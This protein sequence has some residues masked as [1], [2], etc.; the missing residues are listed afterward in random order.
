MLDFST[1]FRYATGHDP[2]PYQL[3]L[4]EATESSILLSV[5]TGLGKTDAVVMAWLYRRRYAEHNVQAATPRRLVYCLPMRS[6]VEQTHDKVQ[7]LLHNLSIHDERVKKSPVE[8]TVLM[9]G[10]IDNAWDERPENDNIII[11]TQ[12]QLLSRALNRGYAM[13]RYRWPI[14]FGLLNNDVMWVFD[15]LQLLGSAVPTSAQLTGFR[16]ELGHYGPVQS[17]WMSATMNPS[18]LQTP[19]F[20]PKTSVQI[21]L[22]NNDHAFP[23]VKQRLTAS[24]PLN[25]S[26]VPLSKDMTKYAKHLAKEVMDK[27]HPAT[28]SLVVLNRVDRVQAVAETLNSLSSTEI[29]VVHS[30]FR[31]QDRQRILRQIF[32][33][34]PPE[35]RII[36]ATQAVEAGIDISARLLISELAPWASMVQRFGRLNRYGQE[37]G[38]QGLWVDMDLDAISA[39]D[40]SSPYDIGDLRNS[41]EILGTLRDVGPASLPQKDFPLGILPVIRRKDIVELFDTSADLSGADIDIA[42]FVRNVRDTDVSV[43]WRAIDPHEKLPDEIPFPKSDEICPVSIGQIRRYLETKLKFNDTSR[44]EIRHA[45]IWNPLKSQWDPLQVQSIR[46]GLVVMLSSLEGG[47]LP[48]MGFSAA[49]TDLVEEIPH[50]SGHTDSMSGDHSS[51]AV[52]TIVELERH[53]LDTAAEVEELSNRLP[54]GWPVDDVITAGRLHDVG[55]AHEVFQKWLKDGQTSNVASDKLWAKSPGTPLGT[56]SVPYFRHEL[57]SGLALLCWGYNDLVAYLAAA[58][59]GKVRMSIRSLPNEKSKNP[60]II[61]MARGIQDGDVIPAMVV[62]HDK[63]PNT[64]LS[65]NVVEIGKTESGPSWIERTTTLRQQYGPFRLAWMETIVRVADWRAS[66]KEATNSWYLPSN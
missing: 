20:D 5:P 58:H 50:P 47:Y 32:S 57:A 49:Y 28:L 44:E 31:A 19:D 48:L 26:S 1:V 60:S 18:W 17:L 2:F 23:L 3:R 40:L 8:S 56:K 9:G 13:S 24:K 62:G 38:V 42:S 4:A 33:P 12:D 35:G 21:Q 16:R 27:H 34:V 30:R 22:D 37:E 53:L 11:G 14:H 29:V 10:E 64:P 45:W 63:F 65:L 41:Q 25:R 52:G 59:H 7:R 15:E 43:F 51:C 36:V 46:P 6:L 54:G 39:K 66:K 61:R 55:K